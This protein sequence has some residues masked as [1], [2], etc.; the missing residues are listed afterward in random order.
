MERR[1]FL[2]ITGGIIITSLMPQFIWCRKSHSEKMNFVF[3]MV[4]D[5]GWTGLGCYGSTYYETPNIDRL[6][7]E[8]I[9]FTDGYATCAVCSPTRASLMTGR[10]PA[11]IGI[12]DWVLPRWMDDS[13]YTPWKG[14]RLL[15]PKNPRYMPLEEITFA[16]LLDSAGYTTCHIGKWHLG[17]EEY[18]PDKQGFDINIGGCDLGWPPYYFDPYHREGPHSVSGLPPT[19]KKE[20]RITTLKPRKKGEYLTDREADEAV[21]FIRNHKDEPFFLYL[22]HY[23]V[24]MPIQ[25]K[26]TLIEK[27]KKKPPTDQKNYAYAAMIQSVDESTGR[28]L[29]TLEELELVNKTVVIFTSDNGGKV[30]QPGEFTDADMGP[31]VGP[32]SNA[33][34]RWGKATPYEGGIRVPVII[35]WPG[36]VKPGRVSHL[37]ITTVDYFPTILEIAGLN[38][39]ADR[40]IDG[41]SLV[42]ILKNSGNLKRKAIFWHYPHYHRYTNSPY[43]IIRSGDWKLIKWYDHSKQFELY[44][45][46]DDISEKN[47]LSRKMP[48]KVKK[49]NS[50][51]ETWLKSVGAKMPVLNPEYK[52]V[53]KKKKSK[54]KF[55][56]SFID[57]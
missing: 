39:P 13:D 5:L 55:L 3:I 10:Y 4:D 48:E 51:L 18:Y 34:L 33:P 22:A 56:N 24:H 20:G 35:R 6:A 23:A 2:K 49:L 25:A 29:K 40:P 47:D 31:R 11:R 54:R 7:S 36:V 32:T 19:F 12:T 30:A 46:K 16:E 52:P 50:D 42:P 41:E 57:I 44:N 8:G 27:Y 15:C 1:D 26:K 21:N 17:P 45:L 28:V 14:K 37:P 53:K 9:R 38:P 43:S